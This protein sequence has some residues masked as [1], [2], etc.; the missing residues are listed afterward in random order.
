MSGFFSGSLDAM[1]SLTDK[2]TQKESEQKDSIVE[3][4]EAN[5]SSN[6]VQ[7]DG[8]PE[9]TVNDS[10]TS[11]ISSS[12]SG[13]LTHAVSTGKGW[14]S[15]IGGFLGQQKPDGSEETE[16]NNVNKDQS[17]SKLPAESLK[18]ISTSIYSFGKSAG[19]SVFKG[20]TG[21]L[22]QLKKTMEDKA[23]IIADFSKEQEKFLEEK[24]NNQ[25]GPA[26]PPWSGV[27]GGSEA[28][29]KLRLKVLELSADERNVLRPVPA[30]QTF[31]FDMQ[32]H[33]SLAQL[34]LSLDARLKALRF[35][36]VPKR[37][38]EENFWRN[39]FY[40][41]SL[42][43][44]TTDLMSANSDLPNSSPLNNETA[45][46]QNDPSDFQEDLERAVQQE[47][48]EY[49][50]VGGD[51]DEDDDENEKVLEAEILAEIGNDD[52]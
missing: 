23:P 30:G 41:V 19:E 42:L 21:A 35:E 15:K 1:K 37:I 8:Q 14:S 17:E 27:T 36:F 7:N 49:E 45:L 2:L 28:E 10:H 24:R 6:A 48:N 3:S 13:F 52:S 25:S 16:D 40:R 46:E 11:T 44:Q 33:S 26:V 34:M 47:L 51:G 38:T 31:D 20:T 5:D 22:T 4:A 12:M 39:Y 9:E 32:A 43:K 50:L 29:E 18:D